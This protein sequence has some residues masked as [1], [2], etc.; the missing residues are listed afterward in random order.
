MDDTHTSA[1][2]TARRW[3]GAVRR[4]SRKSPGTASTSGAVATSGSTGRTSRS[5]TRR[6]GSLWR[7]SRL[8]G[9]TASAPSHGSSGTKA[10]A[11]R[12][13]PAPHVH[14]PRGW[15]GRERATRTVHITARHTTCGDPAESRPTTQ[16]TPAHV[17]RLWIQTWPSETQHH[18][19]MRRT[20]PPAPSHN[21]APSPP[22]TTRRSSGLLGDQ[23]LA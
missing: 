8:N 5:W 9:P 13:A 7:T 18:R 16:R 10:C 15:A 11:P 19:P 22:P 6:N 20:T 17:G 4:R 14:T 2:H 21:T 1:R 23:A 12:H 3:E